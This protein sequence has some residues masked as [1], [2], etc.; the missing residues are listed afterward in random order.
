MTEHTVTL[1]VSFQEGVPGCK[2][3]IFSFF[4]DDIPVVLDAL[5][6]AA[7]KLGNILRKAN[8]QRCK[9]MKKVDLSYRV[10]A[11]MRDADDDEDKGLRSLHEEQCL[12]NLVRSRAKQVVAVI[13]TTKPRPKKAAARM[14]KPWELLR[15]KIATT[16]SLGNAFSMSPTGT[17]KCKGKDCTFQCVFTA[18]DPDR[19]RLQPFYRHVCDCKAAQAAVGTGYTDS[20]PPPQGVA[21]SFR[22]LA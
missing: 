18:D 8:N 14:Q 11:E 22:T 9:P 19:H 4:E 16:N 3:E 15:E 17:V 5:T 2:H 1:K 7:F 12:R 6:R 10:P 21:V 20:T 13:G